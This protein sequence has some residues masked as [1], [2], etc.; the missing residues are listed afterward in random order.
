MSQELPRWGL[1][2]CACFAHER[3][4]PQPYLTLPT[5]AHLALYIAVVLYIAVAHHCECDIVFTPLRNIVHCSK[6]GY[7][8]AAAQ[9]FLFGGLI[10]CLAIIL[11][12]FY[13][14]DKAGLDE[15]L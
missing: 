15:V 8:C 9:L 4:R 13:T 3:N 7:G 12:A 11:Y 5:V 14:D 1:F 6:Y 10:S 2:T